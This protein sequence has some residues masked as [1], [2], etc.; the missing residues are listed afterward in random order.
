M[1]SVSSALLPADN[2]NDV[3]VTHDFANVA[4]AQVFI[5][6]PKSNEAMASAGVVG[7]PSMWITNKA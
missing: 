2:P 3:T 4:E 5:K 7:A 6:T 1:P